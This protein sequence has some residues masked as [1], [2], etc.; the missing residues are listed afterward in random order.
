MMNCSVAEVKNMVIVV[1]YTVTGVKKRGDWG[2]VHGDRGQK[3]ECGEPR[4]D[5]GEKHGGCRYNASNDESL[6]KNIRGENGE[7]QAFC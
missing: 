7:K 3:H 5:R 4:G 6:G 2:E 1:K